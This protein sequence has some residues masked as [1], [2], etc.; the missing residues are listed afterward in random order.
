MRIAFCRMRWEPRDQWSRKGIPIADVSI[1][2]YVPH[3]RTQQ[4]L[5]AP[6]PPVKAV[7]QLPHGNPAA[8]F[9]AEAS[10][11]RRIRI[12]RCFAV[13]LAKEEP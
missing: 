7:D 5:Q 3:R 2:S 9:R 11:R 12:P 1:Y 6:M 13:T 10:D 8:R 4:K